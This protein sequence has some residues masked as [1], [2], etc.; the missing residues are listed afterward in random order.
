[1]ETIFDKEHYLTDAELEMLDQR[2]LGVKDLKKDYAK[3]DEVTNWSMLAYLYK[4]RNQPDM[5]KYYLGKV[6]KA[7]YENFTKR[8]VVQYT[9]IEDLKAKKIHDPFSYGIW[10]ASAVEKELAIAFSK[11]IN[12]D[13]LTF[14]NNATETEK[15][16]FTEPIV[17]KRSFIDEELSRFEKIALAIDVCL[18]GSAGVSRGRRSVDNYLT[19]LKEDGVSA[20]DNTIPKD[21]YSFG[22]SDVEIDSL[23]EKLK[24]IIFIDKKT[25]KNSFRWI[26][27]G[28][29]TPAYFQKTVW[30]RKANT[31]ADLLIFLKHGKTEDLTGKPM[32]LT[33][34]EY[35]FATELFVDNNN[36]PIKLCKAK[37]GQPSADNMELSKM[38][39]E[40]NLLE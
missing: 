8:V 12:K 5:S 33:N 24:S 1:M 3:G 25:D 28:E 4:H 21:R 15:E 39:K 38:L 22:L 30:N 32:H 36:I 6:S 26:F 11:K 7:D 37:K 20:L 19:Y 34:K 31:L 29:F 9:E 17:C 27:G 18:N 35:R 23:F 2:F 13:Y 14:R 16:Q 40:L 10:L